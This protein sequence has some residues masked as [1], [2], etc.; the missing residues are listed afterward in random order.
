MEKRLGQ[1]I[2]YLF[3]NATQPLPNPE[4]EEDKFLGGLNHLSQ[5]EIRGIL[6]IIIDQTKENRKYDLFIS[7]ELLEKEETFF[8]EMLNKLGG[9]LNIKSKYKFED[10]FQIIGKCSDIF[11]EKE[12]EEFHEKFSQITS[13]AKTRYNVHLEIIREAILNAI[14]NDRLDLD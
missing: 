5:K 2:A 13:G 3:K 10:V 12:L 14:Y 6:K 9:I 8:L 1:K 4:K 11:F 7:S